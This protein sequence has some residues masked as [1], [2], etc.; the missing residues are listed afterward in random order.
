M[1]YAVYAM[2]IAAGV[3]AG[4]GK[5]DNKTEHAKEAAP[6]ETATV[7]QKA[8]EKPVQQEVSAGQKLVPDVQT[9]NQLAKDICA[10]CHGMD[11][12]KSE[13][14]T[15]YIAGLNEGYIA[16]SLQGYKD[17]SRNI[18]T[19]KAAAD[20]LK[21]MSLL[22]PQQIADVS[23]YYA[24]LNS[25][26]K[27][28]GLGIPHKKP[29]L[30]LSQENID[31]GA[32]VATRCNSCH[33][34][35][36]NSVAHPDAASLA[37]MPPDYF[38][39][40]LKTY[41]NDRRKHKI[42]K[43]FGMENSLSEKE[44]EQLAAYYA[45]Q[46]PQ[47]PP[48]STIGNAKR[49][50]EFADDCVG[51]HGPD[52]NSLNSALPNL[53]GQPVKYLVMSMQD[54]RDGKRKDP[55]MKFALKGMSDEKI[56]DIAAYFAAQEPVSLHRW[57]MQSS[58]EFRPVEEGKRIARMCDSCHGK[59]GNSTR[60]GI[61]NLSGLTMRY[62]TEATT[63]YRD[64]LWKHDVMREMVSFLKD[65]DIEK[66]SLY[67]ALQEPVATK[68]PDKFDMAAGTKIKPACTLCHSDEGI[69]KD[70]RIPNLNG[71]DHKYLIEATM[72]YANGKRKN[73]DMEKIAKAIK[74]QDVSNLVNVT[75]YY[76][77]QN[78]N[79]PYTVTP[80]SAM[81]TI[82]KCHHCHGTKGESSTASLPRLAGQSEV[83]LVS[84]LKDYQD[85]MRKSKDMNEHAGLSLMEMKGISAY[86]AKQ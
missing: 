85:M 2:M 5:T 13:S 30:S 80:Q 65:D 66:V 7:A 3:L 77:A 60:P 27:G 63:A 28:A 38:I 53:T 50:A 81:K 52:G 68:T 58:K 51:C 84:S 19:L 78:A 40:S 42:M 55:A 36:G 1:K 56:A 12:I 76:T 8:P 25:P 54:Y 69:K 75:G 16:A 47:K 46:T 49:G 79:K 6:K 70:P 18:A 17:G 62:L 34:T 83:Y 26:W 37:A 10:S 74:P 43:V 61:P 29:V 21:A 24:S 48:A 20:K 41:F 59:N 45:V 15:P 71:Q 73:E 9:G 23:A 39:Y 64:G 33:G 31:A 22:N 67:Y 14:G 72:A 86:Y 35:E 4:C 44:I 11:G 57:K 32:E 82:E